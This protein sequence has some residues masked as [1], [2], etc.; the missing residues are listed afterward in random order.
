M[1]RT[2]GRRCPGSGGR[3]KGGSSASS[4]GGQTAKGREAAAL[5]DMKAEM[6]KWRS[7]P[8]PE[9][10]PAEPMSPAKAALLGCD[11][12]EG[13]ARFD[14]LRAYR[15]AGY[16]GPLDQDNRIPDPDSPAGQQSLSALAA[17]SLTH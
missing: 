7:L 9:P 15:E 16:Q 14:R 11:T 4:A 2:G 10:G 6:R 3:S 1:C 17:L 5:D 12:T 13:R 8:A